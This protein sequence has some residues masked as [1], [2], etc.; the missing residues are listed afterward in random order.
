MNI[1]I[2]IKGGL[3]NQMFQYA[4]GYLRSQQLKKKLYVLDLTSWD[5][6]PRGFALKIFGVKP[7]FEN[8]MLLKISRFFVYLLELLH[9]RVPFLNKFYLQDLTDEKLECSFADRV[10]LLNGY[11]QRASY[12]SD[13]RNEIKRL[14][15]FPLVPDEHAV[16]EFPLNKKH[17]AMHIRRGDYVSA[18]ADGGIH[19][20]CNVDWYLRSLEFLKSKVTDAKIVIFTDDELWVKD[21][22]GM[23]GDDVFVVPNNKAREPW[24]DLYYMSCCDHFI[25]SNSTFSWW[26]AFLGERSNS[27]VIVPKYW[28]KGVKTETV[29]ICPP[30]WHLI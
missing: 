3:G 16:L 13:Y 26:A 30:N 14:Y 6:F 17:I 8:K 12:F 18:S 28:F 24:I 29:G 7:S 25:L 20:V 2:V 23:L 19:L 10:I 4:F 15:S 22:F 27:M 11:W 9:S 1:I 5:S 21:Q